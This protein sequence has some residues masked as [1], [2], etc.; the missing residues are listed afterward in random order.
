MAEQDIIVQTEK[1]FEE[2]T[3]FILGRILPKNNW[4]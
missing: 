1:K 4:L 3:S 2:N